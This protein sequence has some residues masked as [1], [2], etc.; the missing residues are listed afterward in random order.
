MFM[1]YEGPTFVLAAVIYSC[2]VALVWFHADI[3]W[4]V[5][6]PVA[7]YVTAWHFNF[8]HEVIHGW[9]SIPAWLRFTI[10][11]PPLGLWFPLEIYIRNH[12]IH[13]RNQRLTYP[14]KDTETFYHNAE[15]WRNYSSLWQKLYLANQTLLGRLMLGPWIRWRKLILVDIGKLFRG[16]FVDLGIW[17]RHSIAVAMLLWFV[18]GVADMPIW[19]FLLFFT[20]SGMM[21]GMLR[22]FLEHR[23][24][25]KPYERVASVESNWLFGLLFLWNNLHI[26]HHLHPTMPWYEIPKFYRENRERLLALNGHFV[27]R[28]YFELVRAHLLSPTFVPIH[29]EH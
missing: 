13:H 11:Y 15:D 19:Q 16:D 17:I 5:L 12:S 7:A 20:L 14:G 28:G 29:P 10:A 22:P 6:W 18:L 21:L 9:R 27:Y 23:W 24:G 3:P 2:W 8:Q 26:A 4:W 1:K 25:E